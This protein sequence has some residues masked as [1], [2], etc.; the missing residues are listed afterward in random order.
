L[1]PKEQ[2]LCL[3]DII[4][5]LKKGNMWSKEVSQKLLQIEGMV[6]FG[7]APGPTVRMSF[8]GKHPD[9][10]RNII[11]LLLP[12]YIGKNKEVLQNINKPFIP[13]E[14]IF[15]A[16]QSDEMKE[17]LLQV[18]TCFEECGTSIGADHKRF[19]VAEDLP[20]MVDWMWYMLDCFE[21]KEVTRIV[22]TEE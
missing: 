18:E 1:P 16:P 15:E 8:F 4:Q 7:I 10:K 11:H 17:A 6:G 19:F 20:N 21:L 14:A 22:M 2:T 9:M 3:K 12:I 5:Y 13:M